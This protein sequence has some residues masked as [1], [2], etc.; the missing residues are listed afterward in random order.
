MSDSELRVATLTTRHYEWLGVGTTRDE[1][2]AALK[3]RFFENVRESTG[4][5]EAE[6]KAAEG[7]DAWEENYGPW[8]RQVKPGEGYMDDEDATDF[9]Q[10]K[11][12]GRRAG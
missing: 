8:C 11:H 1:A 6:W 3:T 5:T 2:V 7:V 4:L 12:V 10:R 9:E